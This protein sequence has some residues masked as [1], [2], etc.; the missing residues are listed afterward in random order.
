MLKK[1]AVCVASALLFSMLLCQWGFAAENLLKNPSF[2]EVDNNMPVGWTTWVWNY[3]NGVVEFKVEQEG[4]QSGQYYVTI[5]NRE[6]R[7]A[8]YLQEVTVSPNSY[9]KLSGWI[10]TE[11]VGNDVLGANLSLEGVTTY[12]KDI[13]GTVDEWQYTELYIKTGENVETI[14]V[15]LG[16]GGYG[17]LNTG[18]ASF[19]NVMLEKVDNVPDGA[20]CVIVE[21]PDNTSSD[22]SEDDQKNSTGSTQGK[23]TWFWPIVSAIALATIQYYYSRPKNVKSTK[24]SSDKKE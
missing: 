1:V 9:Y 20:R 4:A 8:R 16:L 14:K 21:N 7:D 2:E 19:D 24:D 18:K 23:Y 17:N 22:S 13:R 5:E 12:S 6:A 10:K 11:N 3:Q 15:S